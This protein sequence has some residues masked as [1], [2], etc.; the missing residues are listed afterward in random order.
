MTEETTKPKNAVAVLR[1][2]IQAMQPE[3]AKALPSHFPAERFVRT[4][5]TALQNNPS[6]M[7]CDR[8]SV[9]SSCMKAAQD[10]LTLDGREAALVER[11]VKNKDN[12]YSRIAVYTPM[13][14]GI[15]KLVRNSGQLANLTAQVVYSNDT[16]SYNPAD[17]S[18]PQHQ[19]DWFGTRG[20]PIGVYAVA[21]LKD[22]TTVVEVMSKAEVL[23]IGNATPNKHQYDPA[24]GQH[25]GEWWRKTV[26]RRISKYLPKSTD[27]DDDHRLHQAI[28]RDD[29]GFNFN[30]PQAATATVKQA[31]TKKASD[32]LAAD[33]IDI[34][35]NTGEIIDGAGAVHEPADTDVM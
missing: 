10:G 31:R 33:T 2:D 7:G 1:A 9:L 29:E 17:D 22:G 14:A 15:T 11:K 16:F 3:F 23:N 27:R 5:M 8:Q 6:I 30:E 32:I 18:V 12:T 21:R 13:V 20:N 25:Y 19:P 4:T 34:D 26:I 35:P 28:E 24:S